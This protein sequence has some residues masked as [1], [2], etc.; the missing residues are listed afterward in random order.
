MVQIEFTEKEYREL[1]EVYYLAEWMVNAYKVPPEEPT[2]T[3]GGLG[4][5][6]YGAAA[7]VGCGDLVEYDAKSREFNPS[8]TLEDTCEEPIRESESNVFW[9]ELMVRMAERDVDRES[10]GGLNALTDED[11]FTAIGEKEEMYDNEF[12]MNG[13]SRLEIVGS[14]H[15]G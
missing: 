9:D 14:P 7:R 6:I 11:R 8:Q 4:Q 10:A 13:I 15:M 12:C 5:K 2:D 3:Y 1:C